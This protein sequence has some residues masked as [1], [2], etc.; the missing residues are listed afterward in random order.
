MEYKNFI[1]IIKKKKKK[2][3]RKNTFIE[4]LK[5]H[6][7]LRFLNIPFQHKYNQNYS[8]RYLDAGLA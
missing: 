8:G 4:V 6:L 2:K 1:P 5:L 7:I 3:R